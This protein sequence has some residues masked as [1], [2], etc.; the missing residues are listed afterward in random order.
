MQPRKE[1]NIQSIFELNFMGYLT[2]NPY[3]T[4]N[5]YVGEPDK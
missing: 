1:S 3:S 5:N 2:F 4:N